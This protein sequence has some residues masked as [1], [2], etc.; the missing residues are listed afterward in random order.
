MKI[1][2]V[3]LTLCLVCSLCGGAAFASSP[4]STERELSPYV[5][6]KAS[7]FRQSENLEINSSFGHETVV[8]ENANPLRAAI[9]LQY[10]KMFRIEAEYTDNGKK[11]TNL[12]SGEAAQLFHRD[13][14]ES[15][16]MN[17]YYDIKLAQNL[18]PYIGAGLGYGHIKN[19]IFDLMT[20][21]PMSR[22]FDMFVWQAGAGLG[23]ELSENF[24]L[25]FGY[26]YIDFGSKKFKEDFGFG[27]PII[28]VSL[29]MKRAGHEF[30]FGF[31]FNF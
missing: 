26:R 17:L 29:E 15:Y 30:S 7:I 21:E 11:P 25:D 5:S 3:C 10:N 16:M 4:S 2:N 31:R 9:G 22:N 6:L 28:P 23:Y 13:S 24:T 18:S 8:A 20:G 27:F 1:S 12:A 14:S 19:T